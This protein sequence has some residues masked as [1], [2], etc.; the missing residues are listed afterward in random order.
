MRYQRR[1]K[2]G[3]FPIFLRRFPLYVS[4]I[5]LLLTGLPVFAQDDYLL[6]LEAEVQKVDPTGGVSG[7]E[8]AASA[9]GPAAE[10]SGAGENSEAAFESLLETQYRGTYAFYKQLPIST[11][12]EIYNR[13]V[14]GADMATV[15][16]LIVE[17]YLSR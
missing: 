9:E 2:S 11:R 6:Q 8:A 5:P 16:E 4:G 3:C 7:S 1:E 15:R 13:Y 17:R 12:D 10:K 14:K